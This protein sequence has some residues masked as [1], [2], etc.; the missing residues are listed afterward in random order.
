MLTYIKIG[1]VLIIFKKKEK[2][3]NRNMKIGMI[4]KIMKNIKIRM[5]KYVGMPLFFYFFGIFC[6]PLFM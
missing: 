4:E 3:K 5:Q 2:R 6:M 1:I